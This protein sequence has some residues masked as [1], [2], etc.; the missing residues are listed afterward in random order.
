MTRQLC[1]S[2]PLVLVMMASNVI[3]SIDPVHCDNAP[4]R[5]LSAYANISFTNRCWR[6]AFFVINDRMSPA[7]VFALAAHPSAKLG[8]CGEGGDVR[9]GGPAVGEPELG[10]FTNDT[11]SFY[12]LIL[13]RNF[14]R[15]LFA[16]TSQ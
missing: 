5:R 2:I 10:S 14:S 6:S 4:K 16:N 3:S 13:M 1:L 15:D 11:A 8:M 9:L 7:V 12:P